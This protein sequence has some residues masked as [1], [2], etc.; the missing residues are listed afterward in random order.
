M[1]K[2]I[3]KQNMDIEAPEFW[4]KIEEPNQKVNYMNKVAYIIIACAMVISLISFIPNNRIA[5]NENKE[6][7]LVN[8]S[9]EVAQMEEFN[10]LSEHPMARMLA[11]WVFDVTNKDELYEYSDIV[12]K[13]NFIKRGEV[14]MP[15]QDAMIYT[16][17]IF[18]INKSYKGNFQETEEIEVLIPGGAIKVQEYISLLEEK[19][20]QKLYFKPIKEELGGG[21]IEP[22]SYYEMEQ[23]EMI[24]N[25]YGTNPVLNANK[26]VLLYLNY[27]DISNEY[28]VA[29][30]TNGYKEIK[31]GKA[32]S[33]NDE[34]MPIFSIDYVVPRVATTGMSENSW[35][36]DPNIP[37]NLISNNSIVAK[38][39]IISKSK[40]IFL[41]KSEK[42][43]TFYP[44]TPINIE[45]KEILYVEEDFIDENII[46]IRGGEVTYAQEIE[47]LP[48]TSTKKR[49]IWNLTLEEQNTL[50]TNY[51]TEYDYNMTDGEEYVCIIDKQVEDIYIVSANGY[52][53]F[54]IQGDDFINVLTGNVLTIPH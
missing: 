41:P 13:G 35:A 24:Y 8:E 49:G 34:Y 3:L 50:T 45:V 33:V 10:P 44:Y 22:N 37:T 4:S 30:I 16:E 43:Y 28:M 54:K 40:S 19:A 36:I 46:Y 20:P 39:K 47:A 5:P 7:A 6:A 52:G 32:Y 2:K 26:E 9:L 15:F 48:E 53:I 23:E 31:D 42:F 1:S 25:N 17:Y 12:V 14:A 18:E 38:I 21:N 51:T 11:D 27:N 29:A